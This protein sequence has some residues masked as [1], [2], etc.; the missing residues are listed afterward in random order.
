MSAS[1]AERWAGAYTDAR[2]EMLAEIDGLSV[3]AGDAGGAVEPSRVESVGWFAGAKPLNTIFAG[4]TMR[5]REQRH[6]AVTAILGQLGPAPVD[7]TIW[8]ASKVL[9]TE[10]PGVIASSWLL[11]HRD[12]RVFVM[13]GVFNEGTSSMNP[14]SVG[15]LLIGSAETHARVAPRVEDNDPSGGGTIA[16]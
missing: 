8:S 14:A 7:S 5:G 10:E 13:T 4:I 16:P 12:G 9:N 11:A 15:A 6:S 2:R 3:G 1:F